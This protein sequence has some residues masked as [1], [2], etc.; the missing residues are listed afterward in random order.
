M[1]E[2]ISTVFPE[3]DSFLMKR[4]VFPEKRKKNSAK[5]P[6]MPF[7]GEKD[8]LAYQNNRVI[9]ETCQANPGSKSFKL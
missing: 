2:R 1:I 4:K 9:G 7:I 5:A 8:S 3:V 6:K